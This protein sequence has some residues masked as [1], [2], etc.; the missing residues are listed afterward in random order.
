M[1][2]D[3]F[4]LNKDTHMKPLNKIDLLPGGH[5]LSKVPHFKNTY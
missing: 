3:L 1:L 2:I 5:R 4:P